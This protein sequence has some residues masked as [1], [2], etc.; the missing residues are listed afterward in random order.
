M[1]SLVR[2]A[3]TCSVRDAVNHE[4]KR[5]NNHYTYARCART[6]VVL[7]C[8][9]TCFFAVPSASAAGTE[10]PMATVPGDGVIRLTD[11]GHRDWGPQVLH[12]RVDTSRFRPGKLVLLDADGK[13]VP[14][15]IKDNVLSFVAEVEK[16][17][18]V[19]FTFAAS[20]KDRSAENSSLRRRDV[21]DSL[22]IANSHFA[23]R[24]PR[25]QEKTFDEPVPAQQVPPPI[26]AWRQHGFD[27]SGGARFFTER[28]VAAFQ[29]RIAEDGPASIVY[30]ARYRF[31]PAGEYLWRVRVS[32]GLRVA[33]VTEEFDFGE[34]TDGRDFLMLG[35]GD[36]WQPQQI[37]FVEDRKLVLR[38]AAPLV[39]EKAKLQ[40]AA[41]N[42]VSAYTPP[43]PVPPGKGLVFLDKIGAGGAW[44]MRGG[45][46][47][48]SAQGSGDGAAVR[49]ISLCPW[50]LGSWR[51]AMALN[52]WHNPAHG[53]Q[54]ALPISVRL[55]R[56]Y[57]DVTDDQ[58]PF[59]THEHDPDLP[60]SYG[61]RV[62]ALGFGLD[63]MVATRI[64]CGY[65]GLDRYKDW[66]VDWPENKSKAKYPRAYAT[67]EI[68]A[69]I[70]KSLDQHPEKAN[71]QKLYLI[72]GQTESAVENA[73]RVLKN[74]GSPYGSPWQVFGLP[75]Y[76]QTY[77]R[78]FLPLAEDA[79]ACPDLPADVRADLRRHLA[80]WAHLYAEPDYNPRGSGVHLGNPNMPIGRTLVLVMFAAMLPDHPQY[81]YWMTQM[82]DWAEYRLA[83]NTIPS[84]AWFEPP[85]YQMYGPTR[86][87]TI[88]QVLLRNGGF[89]D[90]GGKPYHSRV[91]EYNA[92]LTVP[93]VRYKGWRILPGMGNS[94]N[95]LEGVWGMGMGVVEQADRDSAGFFR[96]M[97]RHCSGNQRL[98]L[99]DG[100]DYSFF[101]LPDVPERP[102]T[103]GTTYIPGYGVIFRAHFGSP[104]ET[105]MLLRCG[106]N[107]SHWDRDDLNVIL[108][109]KGAP[110]SPGTGYQYY[111]GP[112][113]QNDAVYHN[114]VKP[115]RLDAHEP[116][117]RIE[118]TVQDYGFGQNA[119]YAVGREYFP[120][121]YFDDDKGETQW[122]RHVLFPKSRKPD[123]AN[124]FVMRDTF[125]GPEDQPDNAVRPAWWHWLNLDTADRIRV[126]GKAFNKE[127]VALNQVVSEGKMPHLR[128]R[129]LEMDSGYGASTFIW[130]AQPS[131]TDVRAVMT[132]DYP[133]GPNYHHR[134]FGKKLGVLSQEDKETKTIVRI[135]GT[136]AEGFLYVVYPRKDGEAAPRCTSPTPGCV[137]IVTPEATDYVFLSDVP[138]E[139]DS[140]GVVFAGKAG[141]VRVFRDRVALCISSGF[142]RVGYR[143]YILKGHG[144]LQ[145]S[146]SLSRLKPGE[147]DLGG[148]EKQIAQ[149]DLGAGIQVRGEMPFTATLE[150]RAIRIRTSGRARTLVVT[151]PPFILRPDLTVDGLRWMAGWTDY[152][153]S[154]WGR[155]KDTNLM[156]VSTPEG[157]HE[158]VIRDMT[159]PQTWRRQFQPQIE[160]RS[161]ATRRRF[162]PP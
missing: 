95:T 118:N 161:A 58:S 160:H 53:V 15:Q 121:E 87:L 18:S 38:P 59:S 94:G 52:A 125:L 135:K 92:H 107:K 48:Q 144:P 42:N 133:M 28:R 61:R 25:P 134:A 2:V 70:R 130:F 19:S 56:W 54:V 47:L 89:G 65:V 69:R 6:S 128:G 16:G 44:G 76:N 115:G 132:F 75:G 104:L 80:L 146:V 117:G 150:D 20:G 140:E 37:G 26:Q 159:F 81:D 126:D 13:A 124:Y 4:S 74:L 85:T 155:M 142:G 3:R 90:L 64:A 110:L 40:A 83:I 151:R 91:L 14:F 113:T 10:L 99:N 24:M 88:A 156:A 147:H 122:R 96:F 51:R 50:H 60:A 98:T 5:R 27:F 72:N 71:L 49:S 145:R 157:E 129:T 116:F 23:L 114:R 82:R 154:D 97:H 41:M 31:A 131:N 162:P 79:L 78:A 68:L 112:A 67:P 84:G 36:R 11:Y 109:G 119:D 103:L 32:D 17:E 66:I 152:A 8:L 137:K 7:C 153:G 77:F 62:W 141:T 30:E 21:G 22:E 138:M 29:T 100:P 111:Y 123:G 105:A 148:H 93:D 86:S 46:E 39:E 106:Y 102:R 33:V 149:V 158:L 63:D 57:L 43:S 127:A 35:I 9:L 34:I 45:I 108:Y 12:Y 139:F 143:G 136:T 73:R 120:P 55:S 1:R 101:Y